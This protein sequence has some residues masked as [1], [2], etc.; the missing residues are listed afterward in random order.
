MVHNSRCNLKNLAGRLFMLFAGLVAI[1]SCDT[2]NAEPVYMGKEYFPLASGRWII[3]DV[4]STV[5]DDFLGRVF[6]FNYQVKEVQAGIFI[7]D[8]GEETM[9]IERFYRNDT[10]SPWIINSVWTKALRNN[11]ALRTEENITY[12]KLS[13]PLYLN[14]NWNGNAFNPLA[15]QTY[16]ITDIH[17]A[18]QYGNHLFDSTLRV[19]QKDFQTLIGKDIQYEIHGKGIGMLQ[20]HVTELTTEIDGTIIRGVVYTFSISDYGF[21]ETKL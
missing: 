17:Q 2:H 21:S 15:R 9:R 8:S 3:Y 7:N 1:V 10:L 6:N 20:R 19:L 16:R 13:F 12:V 18:R 5:H 11:Q 4:D 14:R